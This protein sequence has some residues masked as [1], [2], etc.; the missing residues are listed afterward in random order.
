MRTILVELALAVVSFLGF[1]VLA[2]R[3]SKTYRRLFGPLL[4][5]L[6]FIGLLVYARDIGID[7]SYTTALWYVPPQE[8]G[9]AQLAL[10][11]H[12]LTS[13]KT[14]LLFF[15]FQAYLLL[16]FICT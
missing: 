3:Y 13:A 14:L 4:I 7:Q 2:Y 15:F 1:T 9:N 12:K 6:W 5:G 10:E 8:W 11:W 16:L